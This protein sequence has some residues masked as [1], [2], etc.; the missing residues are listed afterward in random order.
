MNTPDRILGN[1]DA[2]PRFV[3]A[4]TEEIRLAEE[5][6]RQIEER[7]LARTKLPSA[8]PTHAD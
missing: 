6:R 4:S 2:W 7:Y 1:Y 8:P 5:L 3:A